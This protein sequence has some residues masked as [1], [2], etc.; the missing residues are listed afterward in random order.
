MDAEVK[1]PVVIGTIPAFQH[2]LKDPSQNPDAVQP[3][4][5]QPEAPPGGQPGFP[6]EGQQEYPPQGQQGY[7]PPRDG[8]SGY[9]LPG[10][11]SGDEGLFPPPKYTA[12]VGGPQKI[13]GKFGTFGKIFYAPQYPYYDPDT[14]YASIGIPLGATQSADG[15][16]PPPT[17][18]QPMSIQQPPKQ[19]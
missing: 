18:V 5:G 10:G 12:A 7:P 13:L 11:V 17:V 19:T 4:P 8:S 1:L 15:G 6:P 3:I 2:T 9:P 14:L 16:Q